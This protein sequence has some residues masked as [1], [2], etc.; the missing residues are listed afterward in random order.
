MPVGK[1]AAGKTRTVTRWRPASTSCFLGTSIWSP[2]TSDSA[3]RCRWSPTDGGFHIFDGR[4]KKIAVLETG[5]TLTQ[6]LRALFAY[7]PLPLRDK[8]RFVKIVFDAMTMTAEAAE[9]Y[10]GWTVRAYLESRKAGP[11][12]IALME[13][14][15]VTIQAL[16]GWE[17]SAASFLKF[18]K[19]L[20]GSETPLEAS[21]FLSQPTHRCMVKPLVDTI[22]SN[23]GEVRLEEPIEKLVVEN[24]ALTEVI[25]PQAAYRDFDVV[26]SALPAYVFRKLLPG[27]I[28]SQHPAL[29]TYQ[30]AY[31]ITL[32]MYY[33][34][35]VMDDGN[36]FI[37]NRDGVIFDAL[38]DKT[39]HWDEL[40]GQGSVLQVLIDNARDYRD[41]SDEVILD[42]VIKDLTTFFPKVATGQLQKYHLQRHTQV[43]TETRPNYFSGVFRSTETPISNLLVAGDW[44]AKPYHY[45]MESAVVSGLR[46]AN[47]L[48]QQ[49]G[50]PTHE[51]LDVQF[52]GFTEK[53][54]QWRWNRMRRHPAAPVR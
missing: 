26:F 41:A 24:D 39:Y 48:R 17:A 6:T 15:S 43:F 27:K 5:T 10:D 31:V 8:L 14:G 7:P 45:G 38:I 30:S 1:F 32:Q 40:K 53:L 36:C 2:F 3:N 33:D 47:H 28:Q 29:C 52:P 25:T 9:R 35:L 16:F 34:R 54:A 46:G 49:E 23:G 13:T 11:E 44:T 37:S 42:R 20:F 22:E 21:C 4:R 12:L 18:N 19:H 51:I 50:L